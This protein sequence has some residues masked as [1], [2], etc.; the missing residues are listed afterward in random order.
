M[1]LRLLRRV[2]IQTVPQKKPLINWPLLVERAATDLELHQLAR[3]SVAA[4]GMERGAC[5]VGRPDPLPLPSA[6]RIV[7]PPVE[8]LRLEAQWIGNAERQELAVDQRQQPF[9]SIPGCERR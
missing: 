3:G 6:S 7:D 9:R 2:R 5:R 1:L 4:F 8:P